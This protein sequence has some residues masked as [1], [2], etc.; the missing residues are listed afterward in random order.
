VKGRRQ[1]GGRA[2]VLKGLREVGVLLRARSTKG[3][4]ILKMEKRGSKESEY[5]GYRS[6]ERKG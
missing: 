3:K 4:V 6:A 1:R 2:K 5:C